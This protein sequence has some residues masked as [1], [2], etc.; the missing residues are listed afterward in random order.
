MTDRQEKRGELTRERLDEAAEP[1]AP[2]RPNLNT[3]DDGRGRDASRTGS[4]SNES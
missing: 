1:D 3:K 2:P 4:D